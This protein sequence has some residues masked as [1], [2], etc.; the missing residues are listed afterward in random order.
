MENSIDYKEKI[1]LEMVAKVEEIRAKQAERKLKETES[2]A[3]KEEIQEQR[4]VKPQSVIGE[5][6]EFTVKANAEPAIEKDVSQQLDDQITGEHEDIEIVKKQKAIF[7]K[8]GY[9]LPSLVSTK[10]RV[11]EGKFHD[12]VTNILRFEDKGKSLVTVVEDKTV[13]KDMLAI[14]TTKN[15]E[16]IE[17]KGTENFRQQAWLEARVI[18]LDVKGYEPNE[19]DLNALAK[20]LPENQMSF[21]VKEP[22]AMKSSSAL[23]HDQISIEVARRVLEQALGKYTDKER[24]DIMQQFMQLASNGN[25]NLPTPTLRD[26]SVSRQ[27][28]NK[29]ILLGHGSAPYENNS[30]NK[31]SYYVK[32]ATEHGDKYVWGVDL[33]RAIHE[34]NIKV[35]DR[36]NL[37]ITD[38]K[39]VTVSGN[40]KMENGRL[41]VSHE[42]EAHRNKWSVQKVEPEQSKQKEAM[43]EVEIER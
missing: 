5:V 42:V 20:R 22:E 35:G 33:K 40:R 4:M 1:T 9:S 26:K 23:T 28:E 36:I 12:S 31:M 2:A 11:R 14:A 37:E 21:A 13:I 27:R 18:G 43:K 15:W 7:S 17:L 34:S 29:G 24:T 25:I 6:E 8:E 10:Y 3:I 39:P 30:K 32:L 38:V 41:D 16:A 19:H